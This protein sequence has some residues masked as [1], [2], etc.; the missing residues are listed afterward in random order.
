MRLNWPVIDSSSFL[1]K[2]EA[3]FEP[4]SLG[5]ESVTPSTVTQWARKF[6]NTYIES[7]KRRIR[8]QC[9]CSSN[10]L[11]SNTIG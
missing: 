1:I 8:L 11:K 5:H 10:A 6:P 4:R 3:V 9:M 2:Q 7:T